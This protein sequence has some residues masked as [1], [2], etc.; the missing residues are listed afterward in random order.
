MDLPEETPER[1]TGS[2]RAVKMNYS[3]KKVFVVSFKTDALNVSQQSDFTPEETGGRT[4]SSSFT[5]NFD[6]QQADA[7][8]QRD[9]RWMEIASRKIIVVYFSRLTPSH[10]E[11]ALKNMLFLL[12]NSEKNK[13]STKFSQINRRLF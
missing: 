7:F 4:S 9:E 8:F 10:I 5:L 3:V 11:G 13:L 2:N 1:L 6:L 12:T